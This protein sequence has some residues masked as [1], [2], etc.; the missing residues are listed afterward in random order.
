MSASAVLDPRI[1]PAFEVKK[2]RTLFSKTWS[3]G[4][5]TF[6][7]V[8]YP[9]CVHYR[10]EQ[11]MLQNVNN[12]LTEK[13]G[14]IRNSASAMPVTVSAEGRAT[15]RYGKYTFSWKLRDTQACGHTIKETVPEYPY[16]DA[17]QILE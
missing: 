6:Q 14:E 2:H 16:H 7:T 10:D 11:G 4:D 15:L 17:D 12:H 9:S 13:D 1:A 8:V 5:G 3:F